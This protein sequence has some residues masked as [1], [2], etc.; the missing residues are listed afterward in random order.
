MI[1]QKRYFVK[2]LHA[3]SAVGGFFC[4]CCAPRDRIG[5]KKQVRAV[6]RKLKQDIYKIETKDNE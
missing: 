5:R 6:R 2:C 4:D 3:R 1:H